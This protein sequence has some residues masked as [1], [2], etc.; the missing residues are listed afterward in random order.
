MPVMIVRGDADAYL[1]SDI[2]ERLHASIRGAR[3]ERI[4]TG[5]HFIQLDEP[6]WLVGLIM[7]FCKERVSSPL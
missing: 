1:S 6:D 4:E 3:L 2:S 5:G 7:D